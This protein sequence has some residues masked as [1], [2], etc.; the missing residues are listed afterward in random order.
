MRL[1]LLTQWFDPEPG[2]AALPGVLARGLQR[3]GHDVRVLTGFPN[4]PTGR[5]A[6]GYRVRPRTQ[7]TLDRLHVT[8]VALYPSHDDSAV[9]RML[10]YGS[11]GVSAA[12]LGGPALR[13][14]DALWVNYSPITVAPAMWR[15]RYLHGVPL[16]A[17]I[18]DLWPDTLW[19]GGF[20][21]DQRLGRRREPAHYG[22]R[23]SA[24]DSAASDSRMRA[25][26]AIGAATRAAMSAWCDAMYASSEV[27]SY[28]SPGVHDVLRER[29]VEAAKLEY[30]PMWADESTF[31]PADEA[32][33]AA[34]LA[35]R[36][37]VDVGDDDVLVLY[38]GA[39]GHA[40]GLHTLVHAALQA[41]QQAAA[42]APSRAAAA[43]R[44]SSAGS[45]RYPSTNSPRPGRAR[46][47]VVIV[48]AGGAEV[49]LRDLAAA[50]PVPA[51]ER[52]VRLVGRVEQSRMPQLMA[53][54]DACYIGLAADPLSRITMP[55]KT[56]ATMAAGRPIVVAA[57]G[58]V[59]RVVDQAGAGWATGS[60]DVPGL[61]RILLR[62]C[63][64]GADQ[65][66]SRGRAGR[67][68][69]ERMFAVDRAVDRVERHLERAARARKDRP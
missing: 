28:I 59:A 52:T 10:N 68:Y 43:A 6:P 49:E 69:Y 47:R 66:E 51:G 63:E 34:G 17:H 32:T 11:F 41:R 55:S 26:Q 8:R 3:R 64:S 37:E 60:A 1:G 35:W 54:A 42:S 2:P 30:A 36:R 40:Q 22:A 21:P 18:G 39:L 12:A 16:V 61:T 58:D 25:R 67:A 19:A 13:D 23:A 9:R 14:L 50:E 38:A 15:A 33:R 45:A 46:L 5:L 56:Q 31:A 29:G 48:G 27:V 57:D 24:A 44:S 7:E 62:L 53:A 20:A 4:Y 65:R